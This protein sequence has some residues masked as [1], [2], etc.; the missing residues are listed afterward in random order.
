M[1]TFIDVKFIFNSERI[2]RAFHFPTFFVFHLSL[3]VSARTRTLLN[4]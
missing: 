2:N 4:T 3:L 1:L